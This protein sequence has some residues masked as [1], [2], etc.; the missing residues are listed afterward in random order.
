MNNTSSA[1]DA[2]ASIFDTIRKTLLVPLHPAGLPFV[3]GGAFLTLFMFILWAPLGWLFLL[4]TLFCLYFFRDP[5]RVT[6]TREGLIVSPADGRVVSVQENT[7]LPEE[8][9]GDEND[10]TWTKVSIFL[11]VFNVHVNRLP[12]G[13][14]IVK[15]TYIPG[16]FLNAE[17]DKASKDNERAL[18]LIETENGKKIGVSQIAG[19]VA[20]RIITDVH[21]GDKAVTGAKYGIIRFG[22]RADIYLPQGTHA[23][24][25]VGQT[26]IGGETVLAD[27]NSKEDTREGRSH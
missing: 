25:C 18:L 20:R 13:G 16:K 12:I 19:L 21:E 3:G 17:L 2:C 15:K 6:P 9:E 1:K 27:M 10:A 22:S 4:A 11:S 14:T 24:V 7:V 5:V 23:Q 26:C 8:L